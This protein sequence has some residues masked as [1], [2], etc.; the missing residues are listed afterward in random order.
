MKIYQVKGAVHGFS[1]EWYRLLD[2]GAVEVYGRA[3]D[4]APSKLSREGLMEQVRAGYIEAV[5]WA[6]YL[7]GFTGWR[8]RVAGPFVQMI[9]GGEWRATGTVKPLEFPGLVERGV[10]SEYPA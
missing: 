4:W 5:P 7:D 9:L 10:L 6:H 8:Y 2:D 3:G 1:V